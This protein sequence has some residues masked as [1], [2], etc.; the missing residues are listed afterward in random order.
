MLETKSRGGPTLIRKVPTL[1][2]RAFSGFQP[3]DFPMIGKNAR[4]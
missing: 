2:K 1:G 4:G 3:L